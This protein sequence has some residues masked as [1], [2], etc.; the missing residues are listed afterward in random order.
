[1]AYEWN[2][3]KNR[4]AFVVKIICACGAAVV[5]AGIPTW[6]VVEAMIR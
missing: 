6:M 2:E 5:T 3:A 4:Q 1:M